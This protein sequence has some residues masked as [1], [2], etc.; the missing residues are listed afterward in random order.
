MFRDPDIFKREKGRG[1][2]TPKY[3]E[4]F[5]FASLHSLPECRKGLLGS[6]KVL[7]IIVVRC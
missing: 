1:M 5:A 2:Q 3:R 4:K 7:A 6:L